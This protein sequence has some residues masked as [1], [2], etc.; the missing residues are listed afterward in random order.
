MITYKLIVGPYQ[1]YTSTT[2]YSSLV[3]A[4]KALAEDWPMTTLRASNVIIMADYDGCRLILQRA[5]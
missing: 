3:E 1:G 4:E 5:R 2:G